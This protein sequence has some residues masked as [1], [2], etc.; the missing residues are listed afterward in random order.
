MQ[1]GKHLLTSGKGLTVELRASLQW[2]G[3]KDTP[4]IES[5]DPLLL[6]GTCDAEQNGDWAV[7]P[8]RRISPAYLECKGG[9]H[10]PTGKRAAS[11][12]TCS[13]LR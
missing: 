6:G 7:E 9:A 5:W 11:D 12:L 13:D 8:G 10:F 4:S 3:L 2:R 1:L